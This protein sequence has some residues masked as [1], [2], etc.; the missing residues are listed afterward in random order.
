MKPIRLG[1]HR[2]PAWWTIRAYLVVCVLIA[3]SGMSDAASEL[4]GEVRFNGLPVPGA[5]VTATSGATTLVTGS[6]Q[7]GRFRFIA[8]TNTVWTLRVEMVGFSPAMR[9]VTVAADA[10]T[11]SLLW[12]L[13]LLP[14]DVVARE[15]PEA[16]ASV[17]VAPRAPS[18]GTSASPRSAKSEE[19]A[20][21]SSS[22]IADMAAAAA[23]D[24]LINGSVRNSAASPFA[25]AAA[26]G[27]NR[28]RPGALYNIGLGLLVGNSAWDARPS[29]F[30]GPL[31]KPSYRDVH[32][33]TTIGGP[34]RIPGL[35]RTGPNIFFGYQHIDNT[36]A[37]TESARVPTLR[38]RIGDFSASRTTL[39]DTL[40]VIDP[41]TGTPFAGNAVPAERISSQALALLSYIPL[42]NVD[43]GGPFNYQAP[44]VAATRQDLIQ[45]RVTR[46][47]NPRNQLFGNIGYQRTETDSRTLFGFEDTT[48]ASAMD[49]NA[50]W[51]RRLSLPLWLRTRY[52]FTRD[53]L[54]VMPY[55]ANRTNVSGEAGISGNNQDPINWGPPNLSFSTVAS[56][57]DVAAQLNRARAHTA[58][59]ELY[60]IR[61]RHNLTFG[62][63]VRRDEVDIDAQQNPRGTFAFTG[64][65]TGSDVADFLLGI[66]RTSSIAFGEPGRRLRALSHDA[67]VTDDF[68]VGPALT[69]NLGVRWEYEAPLAEA[70]GRLANLDFAPGFS[71]A[72]PVLASGP[73]G[74]LTG[75][76]YTRALIAADK[77]GIQPRLA[78]SWRPLAGSS[79]L[80]RAAYGIY[81]NTKVYQPIATRLS[82]QPPLWRTFSVENSADRPFTMAD[83]FLVTP[84]SVANTFAVDPDFRIGYA[85][86]WQVSLQRDLPAS[87]TITAIYLGTS[88]RHLPQQF[89]PNTVP[90][91]ADN[92]CTDCPIG[93]AFLTSD[94]QSSRHAGQLLLRRRL[95]NGVT[96]TV[97]YTLSKSIDD[98]TSLGEPQWSVAQDWRNLDAERGPS[99]TDQRHRLTT[100]FQYTTGMGIAGGTL[101]DGFKGSLFKGWTFGLQLTSGSGLPFTPV[102][103]V[104][105]PG[106]GVVGIRADL[107]GASA[108][109]VPAGYYLNPAAF[110]AP[111][112][113]RW[114][115]A[116]RN[117]ARGPA[118]FGLDASVSR[119]FPWGERFNVEWRIDAR[120]ILNQVTYASV[121]PVFGSPQFGLPA[122]ANPMR[123]LQTAVRVRF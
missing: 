116:G 108:T 24:L 17:N 1:P 88:G 4:V 58:G 12:D 63:D 109:A 119:N 60:L 47:L 10:P 120:N 31:P 7:D 89:L 5:T 35:V 90:P 76:D 53:A 73:V 123:K 118:E 95:R 122:I 54:E 11:S 8:L 44:T 99:S 25:Q 27:N 15:L 98:T 101:L 21:S 64:A 37:S 83:G 112:P 68:R 51:T 92:P 86:N 96:A 79:M 69:L 29:S 91:D 28:P 3:A 67:Y 38:E 56:L 115:S 57:F 46:Q 113:G 74:T 100:Q 78:A 23:D 106:T 34:L 75:R 93:F 36:N 87:L 117:S 30:V 32:L 80:V 49:L 77:T 110:A 40:R 62:G 33:L 114:G 16:G 85:H 84:A 111:A 6:D 42:P 9:E 59:A 18:A 50:N 121:N 103:L 97:E 55:F 61:G 52:R 45:S 81:R 22:P 82:Q 65:L 41:Q 19:S 105:I 71:Q 102:Y 20:S 72:A 70:S 13:E 104:N 39:G 43:A 26:F 48:R 2:R 66:P 94:G 107:T 14:F